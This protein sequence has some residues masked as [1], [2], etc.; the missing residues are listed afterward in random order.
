MKKKTVKTFLESLRFRL[1]TLKKKQKI[2]L[3][4]YFLANCFLTDFQ[5]MSMIVLQIHVNMT[6]KGIYSSKYVF[7]N[8]FEAKLSL[9]SILIVVLLLSRFI[10]FCT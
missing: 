5:Q 1:K 6:R 7:I 2:Y 10:S 4:I 9:L 3:Y 8:A